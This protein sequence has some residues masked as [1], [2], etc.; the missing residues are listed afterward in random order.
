MFRVLISGPAGCGKRTIAKLLLKEFDE[1]GHFSAGDFI[2]DHI[3]RGTEFGL[4]A[5]SFVRKGELIPDSILNGLLVEEVRRGGN[6]MILDGYP[7]TLAQV[8]LIEKVAPLNLVAEI[9]VPKKVLIERLSKQLVHTASG[10]TYNLDFNPPKEE[11]TLYIFGKDDITG[12]PLEKREDDATEAVRRRI[13]V[14]DKT[15]SKGKDDITG[16]PLEKRE[17]D[18]TEAVRRRI[19]VHDKTE[20]KVVDYYK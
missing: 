18:A 10:R 7:R 2:R 14:H 1:F 19:E 6:K 9:K 5:A 16:E 8:K 3:Q 12:E 20:S 4:R 15:E 17:D 13:E 11:V